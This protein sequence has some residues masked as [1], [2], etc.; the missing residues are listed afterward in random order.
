MVKRYGCNEKFFM[1]NNEY[2]LYWAGFI[3]ADGCVRLQDKKYKQLAIN[4]SIKD[5]NHLYKFKNLIEFEGPVQKCFGRYETAQVTISSD[6]IF[7]SL[8]RFNIVPRKTHVYRFPD[9]L[10]NH[11][12]VNH[13]MRGYFDGDGCFSMQLLKDKNIPQLRCHVLGTKEFLTEYRDIIAKECNFNNKKKIFYTKG[14]CRLEY[15]GNSMVRKISKFLYNES[16][17]NIRM[18]RKYNILHSEFVLSMPEN[19]HNKPIIGECIKTG[20]VIEFKSLTKA[21]ESGFTYQCIS[22]CCRGKQKTHRG[23]VWSY[24]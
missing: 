10:I 12:M 2:S 15:G 16:N 20:E 22:K 19:H 14:I 11:K 9:W 6:N 17:Q 4:L 23:F 3:A 7:D 21:V 18:N 13:F 1:L 24:K 5:I 8:S